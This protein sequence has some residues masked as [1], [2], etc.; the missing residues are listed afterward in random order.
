VAAELA[1]RKVPVSLTLVDSPGGKL[2][3]AGLLEENAALLDKAGIKV[4]IN[5]SSVQFRKGDLFDVILCALVDS[6]LTPERLEVEITESVLLENEAN[7]KLV[8]QQLKNIGVS[9]VLDD[10]G[11]GYSSLGYLTA[12][13]VDKIKIDKS[14][15]QGLIERAECAAVIASVLTLARGLDIATTAEGVETE[16]Q[17]DMLRAAGVNTVQG[18]L[19]ARPRP[20]SEL[21]FERAKVGGVDPDEQTTA[22]A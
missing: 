12:F 11:T 2:E 1:R 5:L 13:P 22:A 17:Y 20:V 18:Y 7:Y 14:F 21:S 6:G 19:F 4:A 3:T 9:I 10:F 8:L 15:T 16:E